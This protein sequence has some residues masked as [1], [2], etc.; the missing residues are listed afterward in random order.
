VNHHGI[1]LAARLFLRKKSLT[2]SAYKGRRRFPLPRKTARRAEVATCGIHAHGRRTPKK[3]SSDHND[4][5][6]DE[7]TG[8]LNGEAAEAHQ[9]Q[10][11]PQKDISAGLD[12]NRGYVPD[13]QFLE[14]TAAEPALL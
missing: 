8:S 1:A 13:G 12:A 6:A 5:D 11:D 4:P 14:R 7:H 3:K 9:H 2:H 10:H